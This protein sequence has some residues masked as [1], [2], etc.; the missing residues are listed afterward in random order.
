MTIW[1]FAE[2]R[3]G[4][5]WII[6]TIAT[7]LQ[8]PFAYVEQDGIVPDGVHQTHD[9]SRLVDAHGVLLRTTR[10]DVGEHFLSWAI[11]TRAR[12]KHS[13]WYEHPFM[14]RSGQRGYAIEMIKKLSDDKF[15]VARED[16]QRFLDLKRERNRLW[17][18]KAAEKQTIFYEDL[19]NGIDIPQ[20][21]LKNFG[22]NLLGNYE[23][24]PYNK[25]D[26]VVNW[27]EAANWIYEGSR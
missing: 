25:R 13:A 24:I 23:K 21:S 5:T 16:V 26:V 12:T 9:F 1:L 22:F 18:G 27:Q 10:R 8:M 20:L 15:S 14:P 4:S 11:L 6:T 3:S 17:D 7:M 2:E 19:F